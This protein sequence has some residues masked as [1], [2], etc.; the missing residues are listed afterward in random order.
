MKV[1]SHLNPKKRSSGVEGSA[2][3]GLQDD[4]LKSKS[5]GP[6][7][8]A[9]RA[10]PDM[11]IAI[12]QQLM[13]DITLS[14]AQTE[15]LKQLLAFTHSGEKLH[16][17]TG[18]AGTGKT[19]LLQALLTGL[20]ALGDDRPVVFT[21]L[22]NKA[23]KVLA[24][25][26]QRWKLEVDCMTCC[27]LLGL[28]PTI[29]KDTG[30]QR[31][32]LDRSR[33]SLLD[34]YALVVVDEC[35]MINAEMWELLVKAVSSLSTDTQIL[36]VGDSA[37]LPPVN[38]EESPCF[39][40]IYDRTDLTEVIRYG[41]AIGL[42]ADDVRRNLERSTMPRLESDRNADR[43]EGIFVVSTPAWEK[44]MLRA[45]TS[46]TYKQNPDQVRVL[47]YT[48]HRVLELNRRIRAA[49]Y[50]PEIPRFAIGERL[51]ANTPCIDED[52]IL[53]Q[54]SE[55][56]EVLAAL[57]AKVQDPVTGQRWRTW[58]LEIQTEEGKFR[59]LR[60][61]HEAEGDRFKALLKA[62]ADTKSWKGFWELKQF[63]HDIRYAYSLTVHKSQGSTF[64]DVFVD[65][66]NLMTNRRVT[67]RNQ[68][69]YVAFTRAAQRLFLRQ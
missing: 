9:A 64:Q 28:Q 26:A 55:E 57:K 68:L 46:A 31:F 30:N 59:R 32:T 49:I 12:V 24:T 41:G 52:I 43:T 56:C 69:C 67:E 19:T 17:L 4:R 14:E 54:T 39:E 37:Q 44:L 60:V 53:L 34:R 10:N 15:A 13:P 22:S 42:L 50:G 51:L 29:D 33:D 35:S 21:A 62:H 36:F 47:A 1:S 48:N 23:T 63:F 5:S 40:K 27:K 7:R 2:Q 8:G 18:Y 3:D 45:F 61:L 66:P 58:S 11:A 6:Q 38:E 65:L 25:M 16:L 20:R